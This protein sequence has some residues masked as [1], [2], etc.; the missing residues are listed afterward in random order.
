[1]EEHQIVRARTYGIVWAALVILTGMTITASR[2]QIGK[3][4]TL[5]AVLIA[6]VK[7]SLVLAYF[8]HLRYERRLFKI[9]FFV[10]ILTLGVIIGLTFLDILFR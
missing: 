3:A 8:M 10:P 5:A 7:A 9:M 4:G 6:T 1:M 2:M